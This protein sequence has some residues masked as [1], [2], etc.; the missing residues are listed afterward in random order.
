MD[1]KNKLSIFRLIKFLIGKDISK[2]TMPCFINEPANC[3]HTM[4]EDL[5]YKRAHDRASKEPDQY[6]RLGLAASALFMNY[7][8]FEGRTRKPINPLLGETF[9]LLWED[10]EVICEQ[11]SHHP[12]VTAKFVKGRDYTIEC[13]AIKN[14]LVSESAIFVIFL[15]FLRFLQKTKNFIF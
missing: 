6:L 15:N 7:S 2:I 14:V 9:E 8:T 4:T 11:V 3:L 5:T 1:P 13:K 12:P 10:L